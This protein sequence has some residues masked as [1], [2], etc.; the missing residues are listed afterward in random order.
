MS[1]LQLGPQEPT[2]YLKNVSAQRWLCCSGCAHTWR[3]ARTMCPACGH[4]EQQ[5]REYFH[6]QGNADER[7]ELCK[8]CNHYLLTM[9]VRDRLS[10]P[11]HRL[12]PLGLVHLDMLAPLAENLWN[13]PEMAGFP[14]LAGGPEPPEAERA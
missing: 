3:F 2:E 5:D 9:D 11:D 7:V 8:R 6:V 10:A 14:D 13:L 12:A 1:L 4:D